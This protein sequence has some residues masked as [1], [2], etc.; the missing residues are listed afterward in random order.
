MTQPTDLILYM[1]NVKMDI[2]LSEVYLIIDTLYFVKV[3]L[4]NVYAK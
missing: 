3:N 1:W 4:T 2:L